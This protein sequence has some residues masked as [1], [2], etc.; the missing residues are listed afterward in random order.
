MITD[1]TGKVY[2]NWLPIKKLLFVLCNWTPRIIQCHSYRLKSGNCTHLSRHYVFFLR[3]V[4]LYIFK[5]CYLWLVVLPTH[6]V[7]NL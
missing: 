3:K 7:P 5:D 1:A 4:H 2:K 6:R